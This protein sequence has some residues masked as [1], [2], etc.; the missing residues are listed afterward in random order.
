[1][2]GPPLRVLHVVENLDVGGLERVVVDLVR[3]ARACEP[4]VACLGDGGALADDV[5]GAGHP[6]RALARRRGVDWFLLPR[7]VRLAR[8]HGARVVHCHNRGPLVYGAP[9]ARLAGGARVVFTAHGARTAGRP[10]AARWR[11]LGLLDAVVCVS[12]D[13]ARIATGAGGVDPRIV[14][15]IPNGIDVTRFDAPVDR[16]ETRRRL[17]IPATAVVAGIVARLTRAKAHDVLLDAFERVASRRADA[18]LL[19]V[20]DGELRN[21]VEERV[22]AMDARER[23]VLAGERRDV[24]A[25]LAA[26]DVFVL[27]SVTEGLAVTLLEAMAARRPVVAT[28]VGGNAEV[29]VDGETGRL[30]RPSDPVALADAMLEVMARPPAA[31][32]MGRAGRARVEARFSTRAMVDAYERLYASLVDAERT[33]R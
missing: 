2:T 32:A 12:A 31:E 26:M 7:L 27:S 6:L 8:R 5:R 15:V 33:V 14:H 30:V 23:V 10:H 3:G 25:V 16:G 13:A 1:M 18:W 29:V 20:G 22:R 17:G 9:A 19:V 24:P 4:A 21:A 28:R 11:R